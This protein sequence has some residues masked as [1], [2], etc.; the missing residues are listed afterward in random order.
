MKL[1]ILTF[2]L[3]T[4]S[5]SCT[6]K[7]KT[8]APKPAENLHLETGSLYFQKIIPGQEN[9]KI[10]FLFFL[11]P[12]DTLVKADSIYYN[13]KFIVLDNNSC[14]LHQPFIQEEIIIYYHKNN[15]N[16]FSIHNQTIVLETIYRP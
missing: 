7:Q 5:F 14:N 11:K 3:F 16:Y 6:T 12:G 8:I 10:Q 4:L 1:A 9:E 15:L 2:I 13:S